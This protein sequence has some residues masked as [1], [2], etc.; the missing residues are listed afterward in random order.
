MEGAEEER[1]GAELRVEDLFNKRRMRADA[2]TWAKVLWAIYMPFAVV[3]F[4]VRMVLFLFMCFTIIVLPRNVGDPLN[5]FLMRVVTGLIVKHNRDAPVVKGPHVIVCNH[6]TDFDTFALRVLLSRYWVLT[7]A[8]LQTLPIIGAVYTKMGSVF[9]APTVE[10]RTKAKDTMQKLLQT[11]GDPLIVFPEGGLTSGKT[12]LLMYHKFV[13]SLNVPVIP[14]AIRLADPWPAEHDYLGS[15]WGK[16]FF[17][18]L[19][20]PFHVYE[21]TFLPAI[22][23]NYNE[24]PEEFAARTQRITASFLGQ[25]PTK[26]TY[27]D[28][29]ELVKKLKSA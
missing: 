16:N 10:S 1:E 13:F 4:L 26:F 24:E 2:P 14:G 22:T 6:V 21:I 18:F 27:S 23:R 29:K 12:G 25:V 19:A 20:V 5:I 17:W 28:K 11:T 7:S 3:L 9:V 15:S 8:H